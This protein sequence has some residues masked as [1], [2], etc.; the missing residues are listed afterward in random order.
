MARFLIPL[1]IFFV[2]VGFLYVGLGLNPREIPSPLI[3]KPA[4]EFS[5]PRV[6]E[7]GQQLARSDL[8]GQVTLVNAW[9]SWCVSCRQEHHL[10]MQLARDEHV[11][12]YG[13]NYKDERRDA[14]AYLQQLGDPYVASGHDIR[15]RV[16]LD[17]GVIATP[18]TFVVDKKGII[19]Y[20]HTGPI[21]PTAWRETIAPLLKKLEAEQG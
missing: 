4:P 3:G 15:G 16:G 1:G 12:I 14:L 7:P 10:L 13:I 17:F 19:R 20:K 5:L 2:L 18:E 8:L 6:R 9:A 21:S 11:R